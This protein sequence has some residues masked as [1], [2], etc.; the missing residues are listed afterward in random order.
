MAITPQRNRLGIPVQ[1]HLRFLG[2]S[3]LRSIP[4]Q[5]VD[6]VEPIIRPDLRHPTHLLVGEEVGEDLPDSEVLPGGQ[7][8]PPAFLDFSGDLPNLV[9]VIVGVDKQVM[10]LGEWDECVLR[11]LTGSFFEAREK[12]FDLRIME[13]MLQRTRSYPPWDIRPFRVVVPVD[14]DASKS[15]IRLVE[16]TDEAMCRMMMRIHF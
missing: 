14:I 4:P 5:A 9:G 13:P 10:E 7:C 1:Q 16:M 15:A 2:E 6:H 8:V 3:E 12:V 11:S